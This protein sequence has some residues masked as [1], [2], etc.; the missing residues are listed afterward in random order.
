MDALLTITRF[1]PAASNYG[2]MVGYLVYAGAVVGGHAR[3]TLA[4]NAT[5]MPLGVIVSAEDK[6]G[7]KVGIVTLGRARVYAGG[8]LTPGTDSNVM[9]DASAKAI[10]GVSGGNFMLGRAIHGFVSADGDLIEVIVQPAYL[11]T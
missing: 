4:A 9:A 3:A 11:G 8:V 7:G 6:L 5:A 2:D 1:A 10:V